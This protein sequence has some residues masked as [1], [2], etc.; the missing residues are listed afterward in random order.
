M[1]AVKDEQAMPFLEAAQQASGTRL[2]SV[3][4]AQSNQAPVVNLKPLSGFGSIGSM[5]PAA[6]SFVSLGAAAVVGGGIGLATTRGDW[7]GAGIGAGLQV[8]IASLANIM[9]TRGYVTT[10]VHVGQGLVGLLGLVGAGM[11]L[12]QKPRTRR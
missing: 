4:M 2:G 8:S 9:E 7:R 11:L 3:V 6:R 10:S 1:N 12:F 5:T